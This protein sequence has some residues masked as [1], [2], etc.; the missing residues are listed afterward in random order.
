[1]T[2]IVTLR[3]LMNQQKLHAKAYEAFGTAQEWLELKA[4]SNIKRQKPTNY[5][6]NPRPITPIPSV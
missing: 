1:M 2:Y 6:E 5:R 4:A 3:L